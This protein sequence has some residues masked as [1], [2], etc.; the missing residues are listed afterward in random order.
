MGLDEEAASLQQ[1]LL[2]WNN[3]P[4][5]STETDNSDKLYNKDNYQPVIL[6]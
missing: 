6:F 5:K 1:W 2:N 4:P 3:P